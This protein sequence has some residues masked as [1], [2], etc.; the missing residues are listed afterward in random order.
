MRSTLPGACSWYDHT[1]MQSQNTIIQTYNQTIKQSR[2]SNK[3][4]IQFD[5][6]E[7]GFTLMLYYFCCLPKAFKLV[8]SFDMMIVL[9]SCVLVAMILMLAM[10]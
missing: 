5:V 10:M 9:F 8:V 3:I 2:K 1:I 7:S 6:K 4:I